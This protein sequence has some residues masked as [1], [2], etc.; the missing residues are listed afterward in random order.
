MVDKK[1]AIKQVILKYSK[2]IPKDLLKRDLIVPELKFDKANVIVGPRRAGKTYFLYSLIKNLTKNFVYVNFED[3]LLPILDKKDLN[4]ILDCAKEL[5][6]DNMVFFFD[7]IQNVDGWENFI[8]SLLTEHYKVY[9]TGSN[10][11]LLSKE[12]ASSLRGK[13]LSHILLPFSFKELVNYKLGNLDKN[14]ENKDL[15]YD[16][17]KLYLEY[18]LYGGF[19][20]VLQSKSLDIK[21]NLINNY[22]ESVLYRDLVDRLKIKNLKLVDVT[23][24]Y[25]LNLFSNN[26]SISFFENYLKSNK[27]SYSLE[28]VY[29][30]LHSLQDI[31]LINYTKEYSKSFKKSE[32][33]KAKIYLFDL[34]YIRF[35][36][37]ESQDNGRILE[38][39][40]FI[41]L[42][43][44]LKSINPKLFY[45]KN[46]NISECDFV[47]EKQGQ[48]TN[49]IQVTYEL[50]SQNKA[51]EI[52]GLLDAMV[53]F[54]LKEGVIL[55]NDQEDLIKI[56]NKNVYVIPIWKWLL[57]EEIL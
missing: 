41:E 44:R 29:N 19:P 25:L 8:I 46:K 21:N 27:I 23:I 28:D 45:Y 33:S 53:K 51:R 17:K 24:K 31:F 4:L 13:S 43:R 35:I 12:I 5:Y 18:F 57:K 56:E 9:I 52:R 15:I 2:L 34:G 48:V 10:S 38:N 20:E 6:G 55:T 3:N 37:R 40:V 7:E 32:I 14:W 16:V 47:I 22:F 42:Y 1:N 26:F 36:A 30:I 49:A 39:L 54:N 11:K 50:N